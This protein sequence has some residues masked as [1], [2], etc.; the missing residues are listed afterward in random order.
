MGEPIKRFEDLELPDAERISAVEAALTEEG[1]RAFL[2]ELLRSLTQAQAMGN[3]RPI[4]DTIDAWYRTL[5]FI[6]NGADAHYQEE[7]DEGR[8]LNAGEVRES[9]DL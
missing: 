4:Q 2:L 1:S 3:M 9:L 5:V 7:E 6:R 8:L